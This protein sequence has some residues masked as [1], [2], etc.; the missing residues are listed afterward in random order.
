MLYC[1]TDLS[2]NNWSEFAPIHSIVRI[3]LGSIES[4]W[5]SVPSCN[6]VQQGAILAYSY[7]RTMT[8]RARFSRLST[9]TKIPGPARSF[10][11]LPFLPGGNERCSRRIE[12]AV[13]LQ[14]DGAT[15]STEAVI[16]TS[17]NVRSKYLLPS[18]LY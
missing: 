1:T 2:M 15:Q 10:R 14:I 17:V 16:G 3:Q 4:E 9:W 13:Y 5:Y 18:D 12:S 7:R 6:H 11:S 8:A